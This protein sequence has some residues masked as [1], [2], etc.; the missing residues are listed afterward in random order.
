MYIQ[1][2]NIQ[3]STI[4]RGKHHH[5]KATYPMQFG[6]NHPFIRIINAF[7]VVKYWGCWAITVLCFRDLFKE[8][9]MLQLFF[10]KQNKN[11]TCTYIP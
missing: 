7:I 4:Q 9:K 5:F 11:S 6:F 8:F 2:I 10:E 3:V 1:G